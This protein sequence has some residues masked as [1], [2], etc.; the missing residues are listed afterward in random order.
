MNTEAPIL[1]R[2]ATGDRSAVAACIERYSGLVWS[3]ARRYIASEADAEEAVQE[4]FI[5]LWSTAARFDPTRATEVTFVSMLARRRL[6]DHVRRAGRAPDFAELSEGE[7]PLSCEGERR[8]EAESEMDRVARAM[9][10]MSSERRQ[11]LHMSIWLGLSHGEIAE[12]TDLPLGTIKSHLRR[13]LL[14]IRE[15]L[16][17][18]AT[19]ENT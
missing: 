9:G 18:T 1:E 13:G 12:R 17:S 3:L 16:T 6:I 5:E 2:V 10:E 4:I 14:A 7:V 11:V 19:G 15:L 8:H